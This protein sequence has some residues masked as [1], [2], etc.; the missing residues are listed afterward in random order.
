MGFS[1]FQVSSFFAFL[2]AVWL[3]WSA[4]CSVHAA[5]PALDGWDQYK[6]GMTPDQVRAIPGITWDEPQANRDFD[7]EVTIRA[8]PPSRANL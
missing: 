1:A 4:V 3:S 6:F 5:E 7:R 2:L 8:S